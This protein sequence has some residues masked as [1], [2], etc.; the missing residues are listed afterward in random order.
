MTSRLLPST[1]R[2][3]E[4][5]QTELYTISEETKLKRNRLAP[6]NTEDGS[7]AK[8]PPVIIQPTT[9]DSIRTTLAYLDPKHIKPE[10]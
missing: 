8:T 9:T 3:R 6:F 10:Q 4:Y 7:I 5:A 2:I 1:N